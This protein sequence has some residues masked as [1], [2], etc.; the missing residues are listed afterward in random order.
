MFE[1]KCHGT[2]HCL[3][4][5]R[6]DV[7]I[8]RLMRCE[9]SRVRGKHHVTLYLDLSAFYEHIEHHALIHQA[10]DL[11]FSSSALV[12]GVVCVPG[13]SPDRGGWSG[14][15]DFSRRKEGVLAGDPIAPLLAK[16]ALYKPLQEI[17]SSSAVQSAGCLGR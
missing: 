9:V 2:R 14:V 6:L 11:C 3:G 13:S 15:A 16:V 10:L 4:T 12:L 8:K 5:L 1:K 7:A 17:L